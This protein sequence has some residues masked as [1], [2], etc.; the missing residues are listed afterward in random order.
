MDDERLLKNKFPEIFNEI[1]LDKNPGIDVDKL[2]FGARTTIVW[3]C[4][5]NNL[6]EWKATVVNRA[7]GG[8]G[9]GC[10]FCARSGRKIKEEQLL[11]IRDPKIFAQLHPTK[12]VGI[13]VNELSYNS[14]VNVFLAMP[15]RT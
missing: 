3:V 12:N 8:G 11:R 9:T 2:T 7:R 13:N 1:S 5:S 4:K 14:G 6:H 10:P 15:R